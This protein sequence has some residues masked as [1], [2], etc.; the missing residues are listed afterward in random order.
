MNASKQQI[1]KINFNIFHTVLVTQRPIHDPTPTPRTPDLF[2]L[3][4]WNLKFH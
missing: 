4:I 2:Q 1:T 3:K